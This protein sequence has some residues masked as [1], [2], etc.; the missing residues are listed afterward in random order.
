MNLAGPRAQSQLR[1]RATCT[2]LVSSMTLR[3]LRRDLRA[4]ECSS[5]WCKLL[6]RTLLPAVPTS[7]HLPE[8]FPE[9]LS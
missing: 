4:I 7:D 9:H 1:V 8:T 6:R 3:T 2:Y 5:G